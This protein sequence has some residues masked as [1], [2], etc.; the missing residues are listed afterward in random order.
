[1]PKVY[2]VSETLQHNVT[3]AMKFGDIETILPPN[4]QIIFSVVPAV[5]RIQRKLEKFTDEDFLVLIGDPSAIGIVCAVAASK[6]NGR[7]KLL[8]WDKRERLYIPIQVDLNKKGE[9]DE[10]YEFV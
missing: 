10:H 5:K 2:V 9:S 3:P 8:K 1:M 7:F 4:A 6:N